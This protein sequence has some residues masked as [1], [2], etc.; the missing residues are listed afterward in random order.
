[1]QVSVHDASTALIIVLMGLQ[2]FMLY[3]AI[4]LASQYRR[5]E[6]AFVIFLMGLNIIVVFLL[7]VAT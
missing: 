1:M 4:T 7:A 5:N 2:L 3:L 6:S